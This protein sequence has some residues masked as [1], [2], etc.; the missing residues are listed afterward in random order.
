M[1]IFLLNL[2][3][4]LSFGMVLFLVASGLSL[5]FGVMGILN[6]AHSSLYMVGAYVGWSIAIKYKW[7]FWFA[8][9]MGGLAAALIGWLMERAFFRKLYKQANEQV[10]ISFGFIYILGNICLWIWGPQ[11][12]APFTSP[13]LAGSIHIGDFTYPTAR[14]GIILIGL[15]LALVIW[16][17]QD[18][19]RVGAIVR[20]GMDDADMTIAL[21]LN[22]NL[23]ITILFFFGSFIAGFAGVIG[24]QLLGVNLGLSLD[25]LL[26]TLVVIIVGGVGSVQ[27]AL[28]GGILIGIIDAF[29]KALF[30]E[31]A[32]FTIYLAMVIILVAKPSG[33]LG[34]R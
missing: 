2:L 32:M 27:G 12:K 33:L 20:A 26:L 22:L 5:I 11:F 17:L 4:G 6:L 21:G 16:W 14:F 18:K 7:S 24:A 30:P 31:L 8:V 23:V 13:L 29:G 19:T 10:M 28:L 9:L 25:T 1:D 15:L 3:N 34:R